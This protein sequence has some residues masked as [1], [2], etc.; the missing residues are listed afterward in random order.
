MYF[1]SVVARC[2]LIYMSTFPVGKKECNVYRQNKVQS[3]IQYFCKKE[4]LNQNSKPKEKLNDC[5]S[6]E[7]HSNYK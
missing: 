5:Y 6:P 7:V 1:Y 4:S 3:L 2:E